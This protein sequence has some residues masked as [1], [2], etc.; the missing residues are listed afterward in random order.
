MELREA[1]RRRSM[2]RSFSTE[3][4]DPDIVERLLK[5]ALRSPT[6][7]NTG[8]TSWVALVGPEQTATYWS[9]TTD[10]DWRAR[11][12]DRAE[13]LRRAPVVLLA[14]ASPDSYVARYREPDKASSSLGSGPEAWPVPYWY[15]DAA[16][17]VMAVLL[18]AVDAGLGACVLGAFRNEPELARCLGVPDEWRL[19]CAV[20]L[21]QPDRLDH[22]PPSLD[23]APRRAAER[24]HWGSWEAP[25]STVRA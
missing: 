24:I 6:A 4:V 10:D 23:R 21:G 1:I 8:G 16:F 15:G 17:G 13:G 19:F 11:N 5:A 18:G 22:R 3:P 7:G 12:P 9:T 2:V 25:G 14:Y 20:V